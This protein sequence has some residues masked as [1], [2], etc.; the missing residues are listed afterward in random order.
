M[1]ASLPKLQGG[2]PLRRPSHPSKKSLRQCQVSTPDDV[3]SLVWQLVGQRRTN[4]DEVVDFGAGHCQFARGGAFRRY[5]GVEI[6]LEK[7]PA[8]DLPLGAELVHADALDVQGKFD[9]CIGNPPY[10]RHHLI[11]KRWR[12]HAREIIEAETGVHVSELANL[13]LYFV[14]LGLLR[15]RPSGLLALV[16]PYEWVSRPSAKSL[17]E[18]LAEKGYG[19]N[20]YRFEQKA[21]VFAKVKTTACITVIDKSAG[22]HTFSCWEIRGSEVKEATIAPSPEGVLP[23]QNGTKS[24]RAF[25]G[26]SPGSQDVFLLTEE[27]RIA[28]KIP[29]TAVVPCVSSLRSLDATVSVLDERTFEQEYVKAGRKCWLIRTQPPVEAHVYRHLQ[30]APKSIRENWTCRNRWP[31]YRFDLPDVPDIIYASGFR[32]QAP[33]VVVNEVGARVSGSSHG[34]VLPDEIDHK[35]AADY[36]RSYPFADRVVPHAN[37]L[38]KVEV[39]QMNTVL[40]DYVNRLEVKPNAQG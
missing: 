40:T 2:V 25:R 30:K 28:R 37:G 29:L 26:L 36:L 35:A 17:R 32:G 7:S 33:K 16:I 10:T 3:V 11:G 5:L 14:W 18:Y 23:Y 38:L 22:K 39:R 21:R 1:A 8:G 20:V 15:T 9:L 4:V 27:E 6:D 31:W 13:Y 19:V 12:K 34:I 24:V